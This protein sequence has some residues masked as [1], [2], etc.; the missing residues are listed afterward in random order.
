MFAR[1]SD[2]YSSANLSNSLE[3]MFAP[4]PQ[5]SK[6]VDTIWIVAH[7]IPWTDE[8]RRLDIREDTA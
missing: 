1:C 2:P 4:Y 5:A 7:P 8:E 3:F 6:L